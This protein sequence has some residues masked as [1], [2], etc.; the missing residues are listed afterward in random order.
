MEEDPC[1]WG[2]KP[3][4]G[5]I[6]CCYGDITQLSSFKKQSLSTCPVPDTVLSPGDLEMIED[7]LC[8]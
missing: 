3:L 7:H 4:P 8:L 6:F 5:P 2:L 1:L